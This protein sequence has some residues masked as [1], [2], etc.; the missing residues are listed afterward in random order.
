MKFLLV[1]I[2][3]M[4]ASIASAN[5]YADVINMPVGVTSVSQS[6]YGIHMLVFWVCFAIGVLVFGF[7]FYTM[8]AYRKSK[9]AVASKFHDNLFVEI[10]WTAIPTVILV[11]LAIP[12]TKSIIHSYNTD[13]SE[14][15]IMVTGSQWKWQ[16]HHL[17]TDVKYLSQLITPDEE[18][19]NISAK[20]EYYLQEVSDPLVIPANTKVEFKITSHDVIHSWW[21]HDFGV[22]RDAIPG[23]ITESWAN[24][25]QPGI[26]HGF[27]AE[28]CG[29]GHAYMPV[30]VKVVPREEYDTWLAAKQEEYNQLQE[31]IQ[32]NM[33]YDELMQRGETMY[34]RSCASC[35]GVDGLGIPGVF[36]SMREGVT[37]GDIDKHLDVVVNGVA[38]TAM[39][40][41][42]NQLNEVDLA[43]II[44]YERNAWGND[45]GDIVQPV[46]IANYKNK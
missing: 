22:K 40:A 36:P 12:A 26:Y 44:T 3:A 31:L 21:V 27:C 32:L 6:M 35:H 11:L 45:T 38:G 16:Y 5:N 18:I 2:L 34:N 25:E 17:G 13:Q 29:K 20:G 8:F 37:L 30:V 1:C 28:L 39:Q 7:M 42:G 19:S 4:F 46:D 10:V 43:A 41:F 23:Y 15:E 24:V 33:S 9:G 14:I